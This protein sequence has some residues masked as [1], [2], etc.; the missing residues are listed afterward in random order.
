MAVGD[1]VA[2]LLMHKSMAITTNYVHASDER[3]EET[4]K[5]MGRRNERTNLIQKRFI[6]MGEFDAST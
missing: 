6:R 3:V 4:V 1:Y 5:A 2:R